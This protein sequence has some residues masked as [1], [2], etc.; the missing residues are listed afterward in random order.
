MYMKPK[1]KDSAFNKLIALFY[2][3]VTPMLNPIIYSLRNTE[4]HGALR[5]L[6]S[7]LNNYR[8]GGNPGTNSHVGIFWHYNSKTPKPPDKPLMPYMR[9]RNRL[10]KRQKEREKGAAEQAEHRQ[11]S[12]VPEEEQAANKTEE[13]KEDENI[14]MD[15]K[16][17]HLEE[18]TESQQTGEEGTSTPE[19]KESG[20]E[21]VGSMTE[22]RTSDSNTGLENNCATVEEPPPDP[23]PEDERKEQM[24]PCFMYSKSFCK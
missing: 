24:L 19:D 9:Q 21:G 20:W 8:L 1:S 10:A 13:K 12:V 22:E 5:K 17:T 4:V 7:R 3:V 16:E 14:P 11:S 23:I 2:G 18:T 15:I 6:S